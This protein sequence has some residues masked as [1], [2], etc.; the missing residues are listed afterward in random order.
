MGAGDEPWGEGEGHVLPTLWLP[1]SVVLVPVRYQLVLDVRD[2]PAQAKFWSAALGYV[3]EPPPAGYENW[4]D[5]YRKM[6]V[7]EADLS[8]EPDS[9]V[10][11]TGA[12]PRIWFHRMQEPKITKNRLHLDIRASGGFQVAFSVR[13]ERI[14]AEAA[15][16][17]SL[18]AERLE[19]LT[20]EG[21]EHYAVAMADPEGTEFDIN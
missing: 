3:L 10:D 14:E 1:A 21:A 4:A 7:D 16:L 19:T 20:E 12:G 11:P 13:K 2:P 17:V 5:F 18:G 9:I 6:G 15:R 8:E